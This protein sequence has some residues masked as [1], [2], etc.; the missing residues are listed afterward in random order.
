MDMTKW[1]LWENSE[2][3]NH[4][5]RRWYI[6]CMHARTQ[7]YAI[8]IAIT[9][10]HGQQLNASPIAFS[11]SDR[12]G[13]GPFPQT[14]K[15]TLVQLC[16]WYF[17]I[18]R[19]NEKFFWG[20]ESFFPRLVRWLNN[21]IYLDYG[22]KERIRGGIVRQTKD[23]RRKEVSRLRPL[24][25]NE[26]KESRERW[27]WE[28]KE[29]ENLCN[30]ETSDSPSGKKMGKR[31]SKGGRAKSG[32]EAI[33]WLTFFVSLI[34]RRRLRQKSVLSAGNVLVFYPLGMSLLSVSSFSS[35]SPLFLSLS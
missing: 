9:F 8:C 22:R 29:A 7:H 11:D 24:R 17:S 5:R 6:V 1:N 12:R 34:P 16:D 15:S 30:R 4:I 13:K 3:L 19:S 35:H 25:E 28:S 32:T 23:T 14:G 2:S 18:V 31:R 33:R 20:Q 26:K 10:R 27:R 21:T